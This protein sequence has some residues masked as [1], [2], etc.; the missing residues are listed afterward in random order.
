MSYTPGLPTANQSFKETQGPI[1]TNFTV[2]NTA[3]GVD[4]VNFQTVTNQGNHHQITFDANNVPGAVTVDPKSIIFTKNNAAGHPYPFFL[5]S[6]AAAVANALPFLPDLVTSGTDY[7]FKIGNII[8]N[9]GSHSVNGTSA[10]LNF[11]IPFVSN[12]YAITSGVN[13]S[14]ASSTCTFT[15]VGLIQFK[16][17]TSNNNTVWYIAIGN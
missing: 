14:S 2:A 5:N 7:G 15:S 9:F 16:M 3:F 1:N 11:A 8:V 4:H 12:I 17:V 13:N 10:F 6:E